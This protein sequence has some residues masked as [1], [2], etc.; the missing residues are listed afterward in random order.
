MIIIVY[1]VTVTDES[2]DSTLVR[3]DIIIQIVNDE[4]PV[5]SGT[6]STLNFTEEGG[7]IY[8]F[9]SNVSVMDADNCEEHSLIQEVQVRLTNPVISE[10]QLIV[11]GSVLTHFNTSFSCNES[12]D[13]ETCYEDFLQTLEYNNTNREPGSFRINRQFII[14]V[15]VAPARLIF[16]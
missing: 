11:N 2:L 15:S 14:E 13:G 4:P 12:T 3:T 1:Q 5:I 10:D 7:P 8:L 6:P 16:V 9:T